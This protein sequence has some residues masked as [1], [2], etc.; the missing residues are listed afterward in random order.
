MD[1]L[2]GIAES[3]LTLTN[4]LVVAAY[5]KAV[6]EGER[7]AGSDGVETAVIGEHFSFALMVLITHAPETLRCCLKVFVSVL[8]VC[9]TAVSLVV[10]PAHIL[11]MSSTL[12]NLDSV[13]VRCL[14]LG[15]DEELRSVFVLSQPATYQVISRHDG[16]GENGGK[17]AV[18]STRSW[19][20]PPISS[21]PC[22][23]Y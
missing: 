8:F 12:L 5:R 18:K 21:T 20:P 10:F 14:H 4:L 11:P 23:G 9:G 1:Y 2:H 22:S 16:V 15:A 3:F 7:K 17:A 6:R 13:E 19:V